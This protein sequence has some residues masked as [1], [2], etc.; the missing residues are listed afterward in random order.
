MC[1]YM[2][3]YVCMYYIRI[4]THTGS[5]T[6]HPNGQAGAGQDDAA[7]AGLVLVPLRRPGQASEFSLVSL[8]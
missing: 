7:A 6:A 4:Y 3:L 2:H 1:V 5:I 8:V